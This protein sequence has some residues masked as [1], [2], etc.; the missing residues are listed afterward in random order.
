MGGN[1]F[2]RLLEREGQGNVERMKIFF[3]FVLLQLFPGFYRSGGVCPAPAPLCV[4]CC[5][6]GECFGQEHSEL[7]GWRSSVQP[8]GP[9]AACGSDS[10]G[11]AAPRASPSPEPPG[12]LLSFQQ[13]ALQQC[14]SASPALLSFFC[15][16]DDF[17]FFLYIYI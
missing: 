12:F 11:A 9:G 1:G 5:G 2:E 7:E 6:F 10:G 17:I 3:F 14:C 8:A 4:S 13:S 16:V 15:S